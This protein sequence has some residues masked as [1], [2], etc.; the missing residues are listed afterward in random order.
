MC[1][2]KNGEDKT[3]FAIVVSFAVIVIFLVV[4]FAESNGTV[5]NAE[6]GAIQTKECLENICTYKYSDSEGVCYTTINTKNNSKVNA[7]CF[8]K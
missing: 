5:V 2:K 8:K 3:Y 4:V 7:D 1:M 6:P